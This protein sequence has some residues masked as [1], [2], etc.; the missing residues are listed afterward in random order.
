ME[1]RKLKAEILAIHKDYASN[2]KELKS[3]HSVLK[4][5]SNNSYLH[6][7]I[8][9]MITPDMLS[10]LR[11]KIESSSQSKVFLEVNSPG[12]YVTGVDNF[13]NF[14]RNCDKEVFTY[15]DGLCCSA[16][17]WIASAT[18]FVGASTTSYVGS[19][20]V[21]ATVYD[22]SKFLENMGIKEFVFVNDD[23]PD[24]VLDIGSK[25]FKEKTIARLNAIS[26]LFFEAVAEGRM[27][28]T[29]DVKSGYGRGDVFLA[30]ESLK[31]GMID[32]IIS[33]EEFVKKF[34][35]EESFMKKG[36]KQVAKT[37]KEVSV[38]FIEVDKSKVE[39]DADVLI[40]AISESVDK[41]VDNK[42]QSIEKELTLK[43]EKALEE[44]E[45]ENHL[46]N[47]VSDT[48][49][50]ENLEN[51]KTIDNLDD[52]KAYM[53]LRRKSRSNSRGK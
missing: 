38:D 30:D 37:D 32:G 45:K 9:G 19:I 12:G 43:V 47:S 31:R 50:V 49:S 36:E 11:E 4:P 21:I 34:I 42:V 1:D 16:M 35:I 18:S 20:G 51:K 2:Y 5:E 13:S 40:K 52:W 6:V 33:R 25:K 8:E 23:S 46:S 44:L 7:K 10:Y 26:E 3:F 22:D 24:K 15:V 39:I 29:N 28:T 53:E 17:Y 48:P 27:T 14:L 41:A